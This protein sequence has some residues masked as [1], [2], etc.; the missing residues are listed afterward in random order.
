VARVLENFQS[1][2]ANAQRRYCTAPRVTMR[3]LVCCSTRRSPLPLERAWP[4][5]EHVLR[6]SSCGL[7]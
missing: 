7:G 5:R 4:H 1:R 2:P 3:M 6:L